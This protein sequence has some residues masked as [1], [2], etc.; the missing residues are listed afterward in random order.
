[1]KFNESQVM[2]E[3][4]SPGEVFEANEIQPIGKNAGVN[5]L[6]Q[7]QDTLRHIG[8]LNDDL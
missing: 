6:M 7:S 8:E 3:S 4:E 2:L 1:M 5:M